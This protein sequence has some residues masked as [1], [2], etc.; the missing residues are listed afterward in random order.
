MD[1]Y[2]HPTKVP[3]PG[4]V[5]PGHETVALNLENVA[6]NLENVALNLETVALNLENAGRTTHV[7]KSTNPP[8]AMRAG[9][10]YPHLG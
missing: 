6:L 1:P 7:C 2:R 8:P 4:G 10:L 5:R 3:Y 9:V